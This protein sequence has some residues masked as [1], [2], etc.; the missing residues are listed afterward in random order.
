RTTFGDIEGKLDHK[1]S[2]ESTVR[3]VRGA[4][5]APTRAEP[6][7]QDET[8]RP[9]TESRSPFCLRW[10]MAIAIAGKACPKGTGPRRLA[11]QARKPH[12]GPLAVRTRPNLGC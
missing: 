7:R 1:R 4:E 8:S 11:R 9:D 3:I 10:R 12:P 5:H 6:P 2:F